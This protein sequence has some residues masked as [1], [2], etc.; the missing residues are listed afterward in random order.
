MIAKRKD[1]SLFDVH[2]SASIVKDRKGKLIT[3]MGSFIGIA[4]QKKAEDAIRESREKFR[5]IFEN[6]NDMIIYVDKRGK[7][8]DINKKVED[9]LGYRRDEVIGKNFAKIGVFGVKDL[10]RILRLF[11]D[12]LRGDRT[13]DV[14]ELDI[15]DRKGNRVPIEANV[16]IVKRGGKTEGV[17]VIL[18]KIKGN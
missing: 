11:T 5:T 15:K 2:L 7:I 8:L 14:M 4:D 18:R 9:V 3:L 1:G 6:V 17:V 12:M 16:K 13:V 10:P